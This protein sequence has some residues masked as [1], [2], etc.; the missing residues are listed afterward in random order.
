MRSRVR[1]HPISDQRGS[2]GSVQEVWGAPI[3]RWAEFLDPR[4]KL[5]DYGAGEE[6]SGDMWARMHP[7][8]P[9]SPRDIVECTAG[10]EAG[11]NWRA[12]SVAHPRGKEVLVGLEVYSGPI[13]AAA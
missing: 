6:E 5:R 10:P 4:R 11:S 8:T 1:I 3:P 13:E 2:L 7:H 12:V 9:I